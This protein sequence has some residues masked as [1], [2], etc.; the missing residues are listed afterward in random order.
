[1]VY[2]ISMM[3]QFF[4]GGSFFSFFLEIKDFFLLLLTP[5]IILE[6]ITLSAYEKNNA[7]PIINS[8]GNQ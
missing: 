6:S 3:S 8:V 5:Y 4:V 1:M 2:S 7:Y